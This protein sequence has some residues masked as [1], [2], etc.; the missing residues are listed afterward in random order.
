MLGAGVPLSTACVDGCCVWG[1]WAWT[2]GMSVYLFLWPK[3]FVIVWFML[4]GCSA[5]TPLFFISAA[6]LLKLL[7]SCFGACLMLT[8][9][10]TNF[11]SLTIISLNTLLPLRWGILMPWEGGVSTYYRTWASDNPHGLLL[12]DFDV[13]SPYKVSCILRSSFSSWLSDKGDI[14]DWTVGCLISSSLSCA[15]AAPFASWYIT[16]FNVSFAP[17]SI[18]STTF[19]C[20]LYADFGP[21]LLLFSSCCINSD[22]LWSSNAFYSVGRPGLFAAEPER[23]GDMLRFAF[24]L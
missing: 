6:V 23:V 15:T 4:V 19:S 22:A 16:V 10:F 18:F 1:V 12:L 5:W 14:S 8:S 11:N 7:W 24:R 3:V 20:R 17:L 2:K 21:W 13:A 9:R